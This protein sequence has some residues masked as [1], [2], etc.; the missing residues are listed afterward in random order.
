MESKPRV[1]FK[2]TNGKIE[3][4]D[5]FVRLDRRTF[6][7]FMIHGLKGIK[8]IYFKNIT[9][10]QIKKPGLTAGYIQFSLPGGNEARG[11]VFNA[12]NDENT[13]TFNGKDN[14]EKSLKIKQ[15]I[16]RKNFS[17]NSK[18]SSGAEELKKW[19]SLMKSG[20]ITKDEFEKKKK[21]ILN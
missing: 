20:I 9:S 18:G 4:H 2:G 21:E 19:H 12:V 8:D 16:E 6:M 14:Y 5:K 15:H 11:G 7:G 10:I 17:E 13:L 1:E 3:L